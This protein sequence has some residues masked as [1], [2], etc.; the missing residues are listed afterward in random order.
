MKRIAALLTILVILSMLATGCAIASVKTDS[1]IREIAYQ[2]LSQRSKDTVIDKEDAIVEEYHPISVHK[3][4]S[5]DGSVDITGKDLYK[6][7]FQ[8]TDEALL[9][10]LIVYIDKK[11][12]IA[13]GVDGRC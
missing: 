3:V 1:E 12:Y 9:G 10:P 6:V 5:P 13:Y 2:Y 4:F 8:T 11:T 7:T